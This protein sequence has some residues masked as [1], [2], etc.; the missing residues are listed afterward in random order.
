MDNLEWLKYRNII[1]GGDPN[2]LENVFKYIPND[3]VLKFKK[4]DGSECFIRYENVNM[5]V[6]SH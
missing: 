2:Y 4:P 5:N 3:T 6:L 1:G